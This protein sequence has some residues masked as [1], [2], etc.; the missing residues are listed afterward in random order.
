MPGT[1]GARMNIAT[2]EQLLRLI[3]RHEDQSSPT[4]KARLIASGDIASGNNNDSLGRI[5][6]NDSV[7]LVTD[8]LSGTAADNKIAILRGGEL[9][10]RNLALSG[11]TL[12]LV[13]GAGIGV[14]G[15]SLTLAAAGLDFTAGT[16]SLHGANAVLTGGDLTLNGGELQ[17]G[18]GQ[19]TSASGVIDANVLVN[20]DGVDVQSGTWTLA[21]EKK[22]EV[23][24]SG[25]LGVGDD[26]PRLTAV[27]DVSQGTLKNA[28]G[29][30]IHVEG[31]GTLVVSKESMT[32]STDWD[33]LDEKI[34]VESTGTLRVNGITSISQSDLATLK[35]TLMTGNGLFDVADAEITGVNSAISDGK[36]DYAEVSSLGNSTNKALE[37]AVVT[38]VNGDLA[39]AYQA[40][41]LAGGETALSVAADGTLTLT[42]AAGGNLVSD[43]GGDAAGLEL[44]DSSG[45]VLGTAA[46]RSAVKDVTLGDDATLIIVGE[47]TS[48]NINGAGVVQV[49]GR[50]AAEDGNI[51]KDVTAKSI[52]VKGGVLVAGDVKTT[53]DG[54]TAKEAALDLASLTLG[55]DANLTGGTTATVGTLDA[56]GNTVYVGNSDDMTSSSLSVGALN[57]NGGM[58]LVDPDWSADRAHVEVLTTSA[59]STP[60]EIILDGSAGVGRNAMLT[61]GLQDNG[62][63]LDGEVAGVAP[64]GKLTEDGITA[65]L[66]LAKALQLTDGNGLV[67]S[68][69]LLSGSTLDQAVTEAKTGSYNGSHVYFDG[70]S[71]LVVTAD[72]ADENGDGAISYDTGSHTAAVESGAKLRITEAR[73]NET[74]KVLGANITVGTYDGWN[75]N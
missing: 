28:V 56:A 51:R 18:P 74:Y 12:A 38:G 14:D 7:T 22:I 40:A 71:L 59:S 4:V 35:G 34:K 70:Q 68:G 49:A 27:L 66:G 69:R 1:G 72:A 13:T 48:G 17:F 21:A 16:L 50:L 39:G 57:L 60:S 30:D 54:L 75:E 67:V 19:P 53:A 25:V 6:V 26:D 33:N 52:E 58:L 64:G 45:S 9:R 23:G 61:F 65:A 55:D 29:S 37:E 20:G 42:G 46:V 63:W 47:V 31:R 44:G 5:F 3:G 24:A 73:V 11:S 32:D 36:I 8:W 10:A 15:G 62:A 43:D 2:G 41:T